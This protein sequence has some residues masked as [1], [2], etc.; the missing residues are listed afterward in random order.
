MTNGPRVY[1]KHNGD[2]PADAVYIG[3]GSP[4]GNPYPITA[5]S[6]RNEVCDLFEKYV[7]PKL[8]VEELRGKNLIC[9]CAPKRCHGDAIL[10][11]ANA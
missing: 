4:W 7:L 2:A 11:K 3:R 9:Y 6:S 5:T 1:N 8:V 10:R